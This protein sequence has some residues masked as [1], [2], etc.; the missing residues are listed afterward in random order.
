MSGDGDPQKSEHRLDENSHQ[1]E[2]ARNAEHCRSVSEDKGT[3]DITRRLLRHPQQRAEYYL[4]RLAFEHFQ[5]GYALHAF[6]L[7]NLPEYGGLGNSEPDP[8]A[9][10]NHDDAEKER[11]PPPPDQELVTR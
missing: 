3:D 4:F 10:A 6:I 11:Y 5:D 2:V 1:Y 9:D 8:Q 7:D